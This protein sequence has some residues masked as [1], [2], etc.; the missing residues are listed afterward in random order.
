MLG[1]HEI[2]HSPIGDESTRGISGGQRKRVN[3]ALEM[4]ADPLVLF[5]DEPTSGLDST[6]SMEVC[7]ALRK[8]ADIGITVVTVLHQPR[9]E[10]FTQFH[11]VL[12]LAKGGRA[13]YLGPSEQALPYFEHHGFLCPDKVNPPDFMMDVIGGDGSDERLPGQTMLPLTLLWTDHQTKQRLAEDQGMMSDFDK[14]LASSIA[15]TAQ[16]AQT[17]AAKKVA[18]TNGESKRRA[19][20]LTEKHNGDAGSSA[21]AVPE[22]APLPEHDP[23]LEQRITGRKQ[24][25]GC[26]LVWR[27]FKRSLKQITRHWMDV[28]I[29]NGLLFLAAGFM[30]YINLMVPWVTL[31]PA[32]PLECFESLNISKMTLC[33]SYA[34][35]G[36][37]AMFGAGNSI[38]TRCQ[39]TVMAVGLCTCASSIKVFGRE[40]IVYWREAAG[41]AQP[42]HSMAYFVGK[43][44]AV[45]PQQ[46]LGPLL[47]GIIFVA[48]SANLGDFGNLYLVLF[49]VTYVSYSI[50]YLVSICVPASLSQLVGVVVIFC[51]SAFD[52]ALPTIPTLQKSLFPLNYGFWHLSFLSPALRALYV[53][54]AIKWTDVVKSAGLNM[55]RFSL[56]ILGFGTFDEEFVPAVLTL[57][58]W[59]LFFRLTGMVLMAAKDRNKKL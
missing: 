51:M 57:F 54:E 32:L 47:Y 2:R 13:V 43:D 3:I 28:G 49:G 55:E 31:P 8:I 36:R 44:L 12:L 27:F 20:T 59:G 45:L 4:V 37:Q 58:A 19:P 39:M 46:I 24:A 5:L 7:S 26:N 50:G 18:Q 34:H 35:G 21:R 48:M 15:A 53:N 38:L 40:R 9:Y 23:S 56:D 25:S 11:D 6:S 52:G 10:I 1:L 41:L 42:V 29:D 14:Y 33:G 17:K 22:A 16:E 30:S